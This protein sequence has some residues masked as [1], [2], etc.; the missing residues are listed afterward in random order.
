MSNTPT[1][2]RE[3]AKQRKRD[4]ILKA[5]EKLFLQK[6][7]EKT[8]MND[9]AQEAGIGIATLF[10]YFSKKETIILTVASAKLNMMLIAFQQIKETPISYLEK[11]TLIFDFFIDQ[12]KEQNGA[13]PKLL[14]HFINYNAV[15][16]NSLE[17]IEVYRKIHKELAA[18][19]T[20]IINE[21]KE[22]GTIRSD[23]EATN[24]ISTIFSNFSMFTFKLT[25][26]RNADVIEPELPSEVQLQIMKTIF[27][28]YLKP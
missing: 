27:V 14:D 18:V 9:I 28:D 22:D 3:L 11:L 21:G 23:I 24:Y 16:R 19:F 7:I 17:E 26:K 2:L 13:L 8:T 12:M 20:Q 5:A 10:R 6:G 25:M 1:N 4:I 15:S